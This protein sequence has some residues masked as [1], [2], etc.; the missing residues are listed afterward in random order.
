[1]DNTHMC[2]Y[3]FELKF[4]AAFNIK[5]HKFWLYIFVWKTELMTA[6]KVGVY[7]RKERSGIERIIPISWET[8]KGIPRTVNNSI[9]KQTGILLLV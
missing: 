4:S 8:T 3:L 6:Q 5:T 7:K 9:Q 2:L 1:M